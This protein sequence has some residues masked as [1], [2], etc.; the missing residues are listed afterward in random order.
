MTKDQISIHIIGIDAGGLK[1]ITSSLHEIIFTAERIAA[2]I[3]VLESIPQWWEK[4][5]TGVP[6]P[7]LISTDKTNVL[8]DTLETNKKKTILFASGDPLWFGIGRLLTQHFPRESLHFH[9]APT[10]LQLAFARLGRSWQDA[11]WVSLHGRDP[12]PLAQLLQ[13]RPPAIAVLTDPNQGN[14]QEVRK[15]LRASG[16]EGTYSFWV[17]ERLGHEKENIQKFLPSEEINQTIDPLNIVILLR[18]SPKVSEKK[19]PL[20][21]IEDGLYLQYSDRPGL[22]TKREIRIQLLAELELPE[23]GV[24]W[25]ICAGVGSIGL[26]ALRIR[27]N[28]KLLSLDKRVG[29]K[30]L[31]NANAS[32]LSVNPSAIIESD[33]LR[34]FKSKMFPKE[35]AYPDRVI[36]GGGGINRRDILQIIIQRLK[37]PGIV[38]IPLSTFQAAAE[39]E[40][41]LRANNCLSKVSQYQAYRGMPLSD[42]T[43]MKPMNPVFI[44]K[45]QANPT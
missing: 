41:L 1:S 2:P 22:M 10:S 12:Y 28:L 9:P 43:R 39:V 29:A 17:F 26:E 3:R 21:G 32:L 38:V 6:I 14:V 31:I 23:E 19:L 5:N 37:P 27:P 15:I 16:L 4:E 11:S 13:K 18:E 35:L 7:E 40:S 33:V 25:D 42:G 20:F 30:G 24:L 44:V 8:I 45:G 34:T 36:L